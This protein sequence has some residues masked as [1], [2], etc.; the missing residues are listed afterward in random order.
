[1]GDHLSAVDAFDAGLGL[2]PEA[3]YAWLWR[4]QSKA[5]LGDQP[6]AEQ[7]LAQARRLDPKIE[8]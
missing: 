1:M 8:P 3:A 6:G 5:A 4:A 7:D 2:A